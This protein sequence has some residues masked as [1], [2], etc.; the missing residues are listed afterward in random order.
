MKRTA[1]LALCPALLI[2]LLTG[3]E[4]EIAAP[5]STEEIQSLLPMAEEMPESE[6][7]LRLCLQTRDAATRDEQG[8]TM[9]H[10]ACAMVEPA[11]VQHLLRLG[12]DPNARYEQSKTPFDFLFGI[13]GEERQ[14]SEEDII[15]IAELLHDAG[16]EWDYTAAASASPER[17]S[18][19][20]FRCLL[21]HYPLPAAPP[22]AAEEH[23]A[24]PLVLGGDAEGLQLYLEQ[25]KRP[26]C[27]ADNTLLAIAADFAAADDACGEEHGHE[28]GHTQGYLHCVEQLAAFGADVNACADADTPEVVPAPDMPPVMHAAELCMA[29]EPSPLLCTLLKLGADIYREAPPHSPYPGLCAYDFIVM[30]DLLPRLKEKGFTLPE[31]APL[32]FG[33]GDALYADIRRAEMRGLPAEELRPHFGNIAAVTAVGS[34]LWADIAAENAANDA[35]LD[36]LEAAVILLL[37]ADRPQAQKVVEAMPVWA[38]SDFWAP[39][40]EAS[41]RLLQLLHNQRVSLP[42]GLILPLATRLEAAGQWETAASAAELLAYS[43]TEEETLQTLTQDERPAIQAAAYQAL[44]LR[45]GLPTG[46]DGD[47]AGWLQDRGAAADTPA[48]Q[49]A[50]RLTSLQRFWLDEMEAPECQALLND[51]KAIGAA[52][53]AAWYAELHRQRDNTAATDRM[54]KDFR[55]YAY[56]L[57]TATAR[58]ILEHESDFRA[59][60]NAP[61]E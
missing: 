20:V 24:L 35:A 53:A 57:E 43:D 44:L 22:A 38:D 3:C 29:N 36:T 47:V 56:P 48:L 19:A 55:R 1:A 8:L 34:P 54:L 27:A 9:L 4:R 42:T 13:S 28:H 12:A 26:A 23:P 10:L 25:C 52:E 18:A 37:K 46:K 15:R 45:K 16:A 59:K 21:Q 50:L 31:P 40:S 11:V 32:N 51:M 61:K 7:L 58:F 5:L 41:E 39:T 60:E 17:Y 6:E 14:A 30:R 49:R 2:A 33:E